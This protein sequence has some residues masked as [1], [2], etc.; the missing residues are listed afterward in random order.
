M[1]SPFPLAQCD[2]P[3]VGLLPLESVGFH[4]DGREKLAILSCIAGRNAEKPN[5]VTG[6]SQRPSPQSW[7]RFLSQAVQ[8][9]TFGT[10]TPTASDQNA[11][12]PVE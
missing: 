3:T 9:P 7:G 11:S 8:P 12:R 5:P 10:L 4:T 2:A 6:R 1:R